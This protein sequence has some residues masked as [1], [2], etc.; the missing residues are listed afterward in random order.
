M[1]PALQ[2]IV[3]AY[4]ETKITLLVPRAWGEIF[5]GHPGV[6]EIHSFEE[7]SYLGQ[8][9]RLARGNFDL[10]L[11]LNS[12]GRTRWLMRGLK[13]LRPKTRVLSHVH[14]KKTAKGYAHR[15]NAVEW[16]VWAVREALTLSDSRDRASI[17]HMPRVNL[18]ETE[19][20]WGIQFWREMGV[21]PQSVILFGIGAT[22]STK[23]WPAE[24][25]AELAVQVRKE[26]G[27]RSA[28]FIPR[29]GEDAAFAHSIETKLK[30]LHADD[31]KSG[32]IFCQEVSLRKFAAAMS[33]LR[34]Y[35]GHDS[36]PKHL[37]CAV[38][39]PTLT[40]FGPEDPGEWHPYSTRRHPLLFLPG[41]SCR[42][43][44][45]G[46]WCSLAECVVERHRCMTSLSPNAALIHIRHIIEC[47]M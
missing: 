20:Q 38:G 40:F 33:C 30:A 16:D 21:D 39:L 35:V 19:R 3:E 24:Y 31:T 36:G 10:V 2:E 27:L 8:V 46:R 17:R 23:R 5:K 41:L 37:A 47:Q 9:Y 43:E 25:F 1:S 45:E 13:V 4:P 42:N 6:A 15:P 34:A 11:D 44:D 18:T 26:C 7:A 29:H 22:K 14:N 28:V 12:T 32:M